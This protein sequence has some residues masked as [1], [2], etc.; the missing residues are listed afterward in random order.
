MSTSRTPDQTTEPHQSLAASFDTWA[1]GTL[2]AVRPSLRDLKTKN[3][4]GQATGSFRK[5]HE[6]IACG[7]RLRGSKT[8]S[9]ASL[10]RG[11]KWSPRPVFRWWDGSQS[12][13][14]LISLS[15]GAF[16]VVIND[17]A[18]LMTLCAQQV[19]DWQA[20]PFASCRAFLLRCQSLTCEHAGA[21]FVA[22]NHFEQAGWESVRLE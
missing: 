12:D 8:K 9:P 16:R 21:L 22:L 6:E 3:A 11:L 2:E 13:R 7:L 19:K 1:P 5:C 14:A 17:T 10:E 20:L 15:I 4:G 18:P